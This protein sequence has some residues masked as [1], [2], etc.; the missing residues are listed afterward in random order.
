[1][2]VTQIILNSFESTVTAGFYVFSGACGFFVGFLAGASYFKLR[3]G[4]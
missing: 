4:L 3:A 2:D 1:M